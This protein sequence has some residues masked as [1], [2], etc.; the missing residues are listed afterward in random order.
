MFQYFIFTE[1]S[2]EKYVN[3]A[4]KFDEICGKI[5]HHL[6]DCNKVVTIFFLLQMTQALFDG[7]HISIEIDF[8]FWIIYYKEHINRYKFISTYHFNMVF[9]K[10]FKSIFDKVP[11]F[12]NGLITEAQSTPPLCAAIFLV[13]SCDLYVAEEKIKLGTNIDRSM[14]LWQ[15]DKRSVTL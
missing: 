15:T 14:Y 6:I 7:S 2:S 9:V 8:F 5:P 3:S 13:L 10:L 4:S 11:E 1:S 12:N